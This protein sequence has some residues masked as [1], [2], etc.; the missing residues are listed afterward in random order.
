M[1]VTERPTIGLSGSNA[2]LVTLAWAGPD[3]PIRRRPAMI[4]LT[5][6]ELDVMGHLRDDRRGIQRVPEAHPTRDRPADF[7]PQKGWL[8]RVITQH[9][10]ERVESWVVP[11]FPL[12]PSDRPLLTPWHAFS[13]PR[14]IGMFG[15]MVR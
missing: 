15:C 8:A 6:L 7:P 5:V 13:E 1:A 3:G 11:T 14:G 10:R 2:I 9:T 4:V 12:P